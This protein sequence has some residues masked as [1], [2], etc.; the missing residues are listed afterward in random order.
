MSALITNRNSPRVNTVTGR[1]SST[2]IGRSKVFNKPSTK[3]AISAEVKLVT[4]T[5]G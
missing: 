1:V 3:A 4:T 2:R 5:P